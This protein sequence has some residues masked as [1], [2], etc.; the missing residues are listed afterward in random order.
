MPVYTITLLNADDTPLSQADVEAADDDH[1]TDI[2]GRLSH[3][4][5][6]DIHH[7][8]RH[9]VRFPPWQDVD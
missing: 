9:V 6:I 5:G 1:I 4:H 3:P 2:A 8:E 7:G